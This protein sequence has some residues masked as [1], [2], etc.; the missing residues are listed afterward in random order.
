MAIAIAPELKGVLCANAHPTGCAR[1]VHAQAQVVA[2]RGRFTAPRRVVIVGSSMG[3]GLASRVA[4]ALGGGAQTLGLCLERPGTPRRSATAGWYNTAA[5][6]QL[7]AT[8]G[9]TAHTLALDAF[10]DAAKHSA[11]AWI[12]AHWGEADLLV[13]SLATRKRRDP[14]GLLR[15]SVL[16]TLGSPFTGKALDLRRRRVYDA[17]L[18]PASAQELADTVAVM[19]GEDWRAW[20]DAF[21]A[22]GV[23]APGFQTLAFSYQGG[24]QLAPTYRAGTIG[25]AKEHLEATAN[26]LDSTLAAAAG[27]GARVAVMKALVTQSSAVLPMSTL[28]TVL[29]MRVMKERGLHEGCIEQAHRLW[30]GLARESGLVV[31]PQRRLRLDDLELRD[32]VQAEVA[33][34][35]ARVTSDDVQPLGDIDGFWS[36]F[37]QVF[38][39]AVEGVDYSTPVDPVVDWPQS[40]RA[41]PPSTAA[42]SHDP[43]GAR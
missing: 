26:A 36:E 27:G 29:L 17:V 7:A 38:G 43:V 5:L 33:A 1:Q 6:E 34:R 28:Y 15:R 41:S 9:L 25:K 19:G 39:F 2:Q 31:D 14:T 8:Q 18:E 4:L 13:Y 42:A 32:D 35:L 20:I 40:S 22:A 16:K 24:P 21:T 3:L 23:V 12:R 30:A 37:M 10:D 11:I